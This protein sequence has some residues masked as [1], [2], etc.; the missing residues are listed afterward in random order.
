MVRRD[1][2]ERERNTKGGE[3]R[4]RDHLSHQVLKSI[5]TNCSTPESLYRSYSSRGRIAETDVVKEKE[6]DTV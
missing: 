2:E 1:G 3:E 6:N 4:V 5:P